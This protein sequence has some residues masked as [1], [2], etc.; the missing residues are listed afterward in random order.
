[1][2]PG[3]Q[4]F[5]IIIDFCLMWERKGPIIFD[6]VTPLESCR[7]HHREILNSNSHECSSRV[8]SDW[9]FVVGGWGGH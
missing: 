8:M 6:V 9:S 1:M 7:L 3:L 2:S 5:S 4:A